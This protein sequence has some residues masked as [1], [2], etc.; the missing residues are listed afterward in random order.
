MKTALNKKNVV[1]FFSD[2]RV[3]WAIAGILLVIILFWSSSIRLSNWDLLTDQTTG[4]KIPLALDPFYFLRVSETIIN[5]GGSLPACDNFRIAGGCMGY[6]PEILPQAEVFIYNTMNLFGNYSLAFAAVASPVIFYILGFILFFALSYILTKSKIA[7]LLGSAFLAFT[8]AYLYRT[9]AGFSDHESIGMFAF[10][11]ALLVFYI[12]LVKNEK[13]WKWAIVFGVLSGFATFFTISCWGGIAKFIFMLFPLA[14]FLYWILN[15]QSAKGILFYFSWVVSSIL[16]GFLLGFN[17]LTSQMLSVTGIITLFVAGFILVDFILVKKRFSFIN[18]KYRGL[19]SISIVI[20]LGILFLLISGNLFLFTGEFSNR[21]LHPF[22]TDRV[23]LTV[24]EN[25]QPYLSDWISQT[26]KVLFWLFFGGLV[27]FSGSFIKF[28]KEKKNKLLFVLLWVLMIIGIIF[29]RYSPNGILNGVSLVS[30]AFYI[31]PLV[32]FFVYVLYLYF[33]KKMDKV[34]AKILF[35]FSWMI[36]MLVA[37]R[38]AARLFFAITPFVC[39]MAGYFVVLV[40]NRW[41]ESKDEIIR[42]LFLAVVI[43]SLMGVLF[44]LSINIQSSE[45]QA[46]YTGPSANLQWQ[47]AMEWVRENTP[48]G[49]I[50]AHWWDY[51]YWVQYLG[52]RPTISDG[53][54]FESSWGDHLMGRYVLTTPNP[55]TA[56]SYLKTFDVSYLLIDPSDLGKYPAYS[57]IGDDEEKSDRAASIPVILK[58]SGQTIEKKNSMVYVYQG[59]TYIDSD[60]QY[61]NIFLPEGRAAFIGAFIEIG[62]EGIGQPIGIFVYNSQQYRIPMKNIFYN[63]ELYS[64]EGGINSTVEIIPSV[65]QNSQGVM[66]DKTG[67]LIYLSEKTENSLFARLYLMDDPLGQYPTFT[68]AHSQDDSIVQ[69]LRQQGAL[70]GDFVYYGGFRGP[71]KIWETDYPAGTLTHKEFLSRE[72]GSEYG[73]L[74]DLIWRL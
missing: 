54:H 70:T 37:A 22:G 51:G 44:S 11:L 52:E 64:F 1:R 62:Q 30:K 53:G 17:V 2:N 38:G 18:E 47:F 56:F 8:P 50:F 9:M 55:N 42:L 24:A 66:V 68:L 33:K 13:G 20:I 21:L 4:E 43:I 48:E 65:Q 23:G 39:F 41:R 36:L 29:S 27:F 72:M 71:I 60:I 12:G 57:S 25:K 61:E 7:S 74:D 15:K 63:R 5:N 40:Y 46:Q 3:Q 73:V 49:S 58:D 35:I 19:Y 28:V 16:F 34:P 10:F 6:S 26:G 32:I 45:A 67:A 31:L 59:G 69:S 14:F